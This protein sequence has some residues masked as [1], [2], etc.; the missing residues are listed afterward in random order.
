MLR[1]PPG[2]FRHYHGCIPPGEIMLTSTLA[3]P[4]TGSLAALSLSM[5]L[6]ALGT[7]IVNVGLPA[8]A[9]AFGAAYREVQWVVISYLL[10]IT[11]LVV[12]AGRLG[13]LVGRRRLLLAGVA[14]FTLASLLCAMAPS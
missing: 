6:A 4:A 9:Q 8:L 12:V 1:L 11:A 10:V 5:L 7:S 3:R 13:D 14:L 2:V